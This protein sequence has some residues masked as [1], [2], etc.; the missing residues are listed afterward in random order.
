[1]KRAVVLVVCVQ[2]FVLAQAGAGAPTTPC[3]GPTRTIQASALVDCLGHEQPVRLQG[4]KVV[5][6]LYLSRLDVVARSLRCL[7]CRFLGLFDATDVVFRRFVDL[8]GSTFH[9]PV[10]AAAASFE[11]AVWFSDPSD[12]ARFLAPAEFTL[13]G[14]ADLARFSSA[15]FAREAHF[16]SARFRGDA[17]FDETRFE[18]RARFGGAVFTGAAVFSATPTAGATERGRCA[19]DEGDRNAFEGPAG[20]RGSAFRSRA[21][22]RQ[23]CFGGPASLDGAAFAAG[24]DF[25]QSK[26]LRGATFA[27]AR[28]QDATFLDADFREPVS[29]DEVAA[30]GQLDF[31]A[32]T[33][34]KSASFADLVS[35]GL[36]AFRDAEF[37]GLIDMDGLTAAELVLDPRVAAAIES[38]TPRKE[39]LKLIE[40]TAKADGDLGVANHARYELRRLEGEDWGPLRPADFVFRYGLGYLVRP[41]YPAGI[42]L[43]LVLLTGLWRAS[44]LRRTPVLGRPS[45]R[46]KPRIWCSDWIRQCWRTLKVA[47]PGQSP[48]GVSPPVRFFELSAYRLLLVFALIALANSNPAIREMFDALV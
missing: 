23:R 40:Q 13:A 2:G 45:P 14:F 8:R 28:L 39:T 37:E 41:L 3:S 26:F 42:L 6:D 19:Q 32:A 33:F 22:F 15:T 36:V 24:S 4:T 44:K 48:L 38:R 35:Q 46:R 25:S 16:V 31:A 20:F 30:S 9:G 12:S 10:M 27:R 5:G 11:S 18:Q 1:L 43:A 7:R 21:D 47:L 34:E 17:F 29:F